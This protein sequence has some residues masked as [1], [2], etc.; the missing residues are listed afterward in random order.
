MKDMTINFDAN[1]FSRNKINNLIEGLT[2]EQL[3]TIPNQLN[4][5]I[6]WN[7]GHILAMQ[8]IVVYKLS[9]QAPAIKE[10]LVEKYKTGSTATTAVS[11][12][13]IDYLKEQ[14]S[15][16]LDQVKKDYQKGKFKN[17]KAFTTKA[18][19][20]VKNIEDAI[21]FH[22]FHEGIHLGW[23]MQLKKLVQ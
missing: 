15:K 22:T 5:S 17:Y 8:Q 14:L 13:E 3:N 11:D 10:E 7:I 21:S 16:T 20:E 6:I 1:L 2:N 4:H 12:T 18:G 19:V 23:I 9:G